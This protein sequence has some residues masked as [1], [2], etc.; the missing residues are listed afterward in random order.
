MKSGSKQIIGP[1]LQPRTIVFAFAVA[2]LVG[3]WVRD[4]RIA[5]EFIN[6]HGYFADTYEALLLLIAAVFLL[7]NRVWSVAIG[8]VLCGRTIYVHVFLTLMGISN[9]QDVSMFSV[10][11][12]TQ[13][14]LVFRFQPPY[15]LHLTLAFL[16]F[17]LSALTIVRSTPLVP[18]RCRTNR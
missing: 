7:L 14:L 9:A 17:V 12:W 2:D 11:A 13:W 10:S 6:Y 18:A 1:L 15:A 5:W 4:S 8:A 16:I 3:M